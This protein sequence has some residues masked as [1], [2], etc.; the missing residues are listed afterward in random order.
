M[1]TLFSLVD[2]VLYF[3]RGRFRDRV[4]LT[5]IY[6]TG[7]QNPR[8]DRRPALR[9]LIANLNATLIMHLLWQELRIQF[10]C[11]YYGMGQRGHFINI[12]TS[13]P[14]GS[15][16]A[17]SLPA[18][19]IDSFPYLRFDIERLILRARDSYATITQRRFNAHVFDQHRMYVLN[20][21]KRK[22]LEIAGI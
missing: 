8:K 19:V 22:P 18:T 15:G 20:P 2:I 17:G 21:R 3:Q 5:I 10:Y 16:P 1:C 7:T 9:S 6:R 12:V 4:D 14:P 13:D 11:N